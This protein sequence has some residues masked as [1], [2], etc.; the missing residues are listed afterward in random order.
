MDEFHSSLDKIS[1]AWPARLGSSCIRHFDEHPQSNRKAV[2][3]R[4]PGSA[5]DGS[6]LG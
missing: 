3:H 6:N 5:A 4:K 2:G 1:V